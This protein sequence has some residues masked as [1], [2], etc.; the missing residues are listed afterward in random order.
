M[1]TSKAG[2]RAETSPGL[3]DEPRT[4]VGREKIQS[5]EPVPKWQISYICTAFGKRSVRSPEQV[6]LSYCGPTWITDLN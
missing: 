3:L 6:D 5:I 4:C 2:D 1:A